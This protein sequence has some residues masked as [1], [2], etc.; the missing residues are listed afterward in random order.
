[1]LLG[2]LVALA[3]PAAAATPH[4]LAIHFGGDLEVN[5]VTQGW[6]NHQL[7]RA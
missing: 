6:V 5:P 2:A 4:V 7:E 3:S 1:L